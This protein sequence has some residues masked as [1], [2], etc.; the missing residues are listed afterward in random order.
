MKKI[1]LFID[2][3]AK[4]GGAERQFTGLAIMLKRMGYDVNVLAYHP[5]EGYREELEQV[6]VK[7]YLKTLMVLDYKKSL[8]SKNL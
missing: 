8:K 3:I 6:G 1:L 2:S 4:G 7:V 5:N